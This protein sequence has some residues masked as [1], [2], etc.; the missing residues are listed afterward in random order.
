MCDGRWIAFGNDF[1][2]KKYLEWDM[3]IKCMVAKAIWVVISQIWASIIASILPP[4]KLVFI[5]DDKVIPTPSYRI[6]FDY[7]GYWGMWFNWTMRNRFLLDG[8]L[9]VTQLYRDES[10]VDLATFASTLSQDEV[11]LCHLVLP[12]LSGL[13]LLYRY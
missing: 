7:L 10:E 9:G 5:D 8:L 12:H 6:I 2:M 13:A 3:F 1:K 11:E 4:F